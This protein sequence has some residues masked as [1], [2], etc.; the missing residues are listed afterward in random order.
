MRDIK[1][2]VWD[3]IN[4]KFIQDGVGLSIRD[5]EGGLGDEVEYLQFTG[6]KTNDGAEI[7]CGDIV[8]FTSTFCSLKYPKQNSVTDFENPVPEKSKTISITREV[9]F[10]IISD[11]DDFYSPYIMGW[12]LKRDNETISS[13]Y[14]VLKDYDYPKDLPQN[15]YSKVLSRDFKIIGN[16]YEN[17]ELLKI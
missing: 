5:L 9:V 14:Q 7:Y 11:I 6:L 10:D 8:K 17:H 13:L 2:K 1:F 16:I 12:G 15:T 3:Y 4:K